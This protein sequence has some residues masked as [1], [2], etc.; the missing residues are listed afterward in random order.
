MIYAGNLAGYILF[1]FV[2]DNYGRKFTMLLATIIQISGLILLSVSFNIYMVGTGFFLVGSIGANMS[3][4]Y[5][6]FN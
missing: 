3:L 2:V 1:S 5:L 6:F 4:M